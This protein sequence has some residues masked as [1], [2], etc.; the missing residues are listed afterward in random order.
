MKR[1]AKLLLCLRVCL[2]LLPGCRQQEEVFSC[3]DLSLT[4]PAGYMNLSAEPYAADADFLLG[5]DRVI[6]RGITEDKAALLAQN[7]DMTLGRYG[8]RMLLSN[9]LSC[10]LE[11]D[12]TFTYEATVGDTAYTY[13]GIIW[14]GDVHYWVVQLYCPSEVFPSKQQEILQIMDSLIS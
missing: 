1:A 13:T 2:F 9:G 10:P 5:R 6:I 14:E 7:P 12:N 8:Q 4:L 3:E 11:Q